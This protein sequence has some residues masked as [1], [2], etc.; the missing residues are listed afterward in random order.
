MLSAPDPTFG[1]LLATL[2]LPGDPGRGEAVSRAATQPIDWRRFVAL[3]NRHRVGPLAVDGLREAGIALP[4]TLPAAFLAASERALIAEMAM[5]HELTRLRRRLGACGIDVTVIKGPTLSLR[6]FG[7]LGLRTYRDL[8]LLVPRAQVVEAVR[9]LAETDYQ[10]V[11][12]APEAAVDLERWIGDHKDC[13]VRHAVTGLIV[14]LHW[15]LF[16]NDWLLPRSAY[17]APLALGV[18]PLAD[19]L[20]LPADVEFRYLCLHG[21]LHG[22]TRLRWLADVNALIA[23]ATPAEPTAMLGPPG[24]ALA[25][26]IAQALILCRDLLGTKFAAGLESR[27]GR[28]TRG[29]WLARLAW[30]EIVRSD[31][32]EIEDVRFASLIKNLSHYALIEDVAGLRAELR[33]D[34]T[35]MPR[36]ATAPERAR[37]RVAGWIARRLGRR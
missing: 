31:T 22:W 1:L 32:S 13:V 17:G 18:P 37:G 2:R 24:T 19:V 20:V 9:I 23:K 6:A 29:R 33:F 4:P 11:E 15:R 27:L 21:A 14:E 3:A 5:S 28:S 10:L 26:A 7:R 30:R 12:P 16:D 8:D 36:S 34:L 25:P 35:V